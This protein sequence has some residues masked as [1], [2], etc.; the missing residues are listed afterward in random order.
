LAE[1]AYGRL[2]L[3]S[4][5]CG[6]LAMVASTDP[7]SRGWTAPSF[8]DAQR[9]R[10]ISVPA[11]RHVNE[12]LLRAAQLRPGLR[13]LDLACGAGAPAF[14][15]A[16]RVGPTGQVVATD[17]SESALDLGRQLA[18]ARNAPNVEF[19]VADASALPFPDLSFD[20]VTCRFG[21]MYFPDL[22]QALRETFRVLRPSGRLAWLAWG[23][24]EQPYFEATALT[25]FRHSGLKS[26]PPE[27]LQPFRFGSGGILS[28]ALE[29]AGFLDV[30]ETL[31]EVPLRWPTTPEVLTEYWWGQIAPPFQP[32]VD[33]LTPR[34][35]EE[36]IAE[37]T[38]EFQR[39]FVDGQVQLTAKVI[40]VTGV[41]RS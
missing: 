39:S 22:P 28:R 41:R 40:L 23:P 32:V 14:D 12:V 24:I 6:F 13:V 26:L 15:V 1:P 25:V 18:R 8:A 11:F 7:P 29:S 9:W 20:R 37:T 27:A 17:I 4:R 36:A 33:R 16:S 34:Q 2:G 19:Q 31:H 21:V 30:K 5:E 3:C 35:K 38:A 10:E